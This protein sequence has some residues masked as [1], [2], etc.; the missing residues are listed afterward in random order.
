MCGHID[1]KINDHAFAIENGGLVGSAAVFQCQWRAADF[2]SLNRG[3]DDQQ[4]GHEEMA[5]G[6]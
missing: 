6:C 2:L 5:A 1:A 3:G 4:G